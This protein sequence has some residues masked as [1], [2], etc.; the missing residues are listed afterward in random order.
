MKKKI[1]YLVIKCL[2]LSVLFVGAFSTT[3][4]AANTESYTYGDIT[5]VTVYTG[6]SEP[7][8]YV[9]N[10]SSSASGYQTI[11]SYVMGCDVTSIA[12]SAFDYCS[13]ITGVSIPSSITS[14]GANAFT[15]CTSLTNVYIPSSVTYI[16]EYAFSGCSSLSSVSLPK[17]TTINKYTFNNCKNLTSVTIPAG[18][19]TINSFAFSNCTNLTSI[20]IPDSVKTIG[21]NAFSGCNNLKDIHYSEN[22]FV[23]N[24]ITIKS[25][26]ECLEKATW[27]CLTCETHAYTNE[28]DAECNECGH[29]REAP[30]VYTNECDADCNVCDNQRSAH[31]YEWIIDAEPSCIDGLKHEECTLCHN[32]RSNDTI[33]T[34]TGKHVY[35]DKNDTICNICYRKRFYINYDLNGGKSGPQ[36]TYAETKNIQISGTVPSKTGYVFMGWNVLGDNTV[37][38][39]PNDTIEFKDDIFLIA[40]WK[41]E[42]KTCNNSGSLSEQTDC[43]HCQGDGSIESTKNCSSCGGSGNITESEWKSCIHCDGRGWFVDEITGCPW[44]GKY[45]TCSNSGTPCWLCGSTNGFSGYL[46]GCAGCDENGMHEIH[47]D[48]TRCDGEGGDYST[49]T[50]SCVGCGGTGKRTTTSTCSNCSGKGFNTTIFT[51][52]ACNGGTNCITHDYDFS[53]VINENSHKRVCSTCGHIAIEEHTWDNG[54]LIAPPTDTTSGLR[55]FKC[56]YCTATKEEYEAVN[57]YICGDVTGD[58]I[59]NGFDIIRL[60]KYL[61]NYDDATETSS[62]DISLGADANGD[63]N[64]NGFDV[65]RLKKYL[66][67]PDDPTMFYKITWKN[68]DGTVLETDTAAYG[69]IPTYDGAT[70]TK[71]GTEA[72]LYLFVG[73]DKIVSSATSDVTYTATFV[74]KENKYTVVWKNYDGSILETDTDVLHGA[75]PTFDGE[76]P[77]KKADVMYAYTFKGWDM[78]ASA[79]TKDITYTAIYTRIQLCDYVVN[80]D[81]NGGVNAPNAQGKQKNQ[82]L[83][84]SSTVPTR[85]GYIF[86][87]WN[88]LYESTVYQAGSAFNSNMNLTMFAMWEMQCDQCDGTG[89]EMAQITCSK[90][91]GAGEITIRDICLDC[92]GDG[93]MA[94]DYRDCTYCFGPGD[95]DCRCSGRGYIWDINMPDSYC[96][97]CNGT[98]YIDRTYACSS[99]GGK[100]STDEYVACSKCDGTKI[101]KQVAP[102]VDSKDH[103]TISLVEKNGYEYSI[104]GENWQTSG[105]FEDL[106][107]ETEYIFYQRIAANDTIPFGVTSAPLTE[108]TRSLPK[109][110]INY[111]LDGGTTSNPKT[112]T[113]ESDT[114]VLSAPKK[115]GYTFTGWTG[116]GYGD[117]TMDISIPTGSTGNLSFEAHWTINQYTISFNTSGGSSVDSITQ[118]YGTNVTAPTEPT[119]AEK[120]FAGWYD[121]TLTTEYTFDT[122]PAQNITLYAKWVNYEVNLDCDN[123]T[124]ISVNDTITNPE[125]YNAKATDTD[126]NPVDI[127]AT[128]VGGSQT[129]GDTITIRLVAIGLYGVY[130]VKTISNIKVY[131][132][133]VIVF[134]TSKDSIN[135]SDAIDADL[136][137]AV[138]T[139]SHGENVSVSLSVKESSFD[140]GD[141][142]TIIISATDI[143]GNTRIIEIPNVRVYG[144]P[145]ISRDTTITEMKETDIV[146]SE[147][148][149]VTAIDSFGTPLAVTTSI[150]SGK[151]SA[152][153]IISVKSSVTDGNGNYQEITYDVKVYGLPTISN[154]STTTFKTSDNITLSSLGVVAKDSF[155]NTLENVSLELIEGMQISGATLKYTVTA[156]DHLG[157]VSTKVI[158]D[159]KIYDALTITYDTNKLSMNV[160]DK[161]DASLFSAVAKDS[162]NN[163]VNVVVTLESGTFAGGNIVQYRLTA[164]DH[165]GNTHYV[166][167]EGIKVYSSDNITLNYS[168]AA[169]NYIKKDSNGEEFYASATNG[170]GETCSTKIV[171]ATGYSIV[172]GKTINLYI[173]ATDCMGNTK[174]SELISNI[175]IYDTPTIS[176]AREYDYIQNGDSP[177]ALFSVKD[178]FGG[179]LLFDIEIVSGSLDVNETIRYRITSKDRAGNKI[180]KEYE[181]VVLAENESILELYKDNMLVGTQRVVKGESYSL[182]CYADDVYIWCIGFTPFTDENGN[183]LAVWDKDSNGYKLTANLRF[184]MNGSAIEGLTDFGKTLADIKIPNNVTSI[185]NDAFKNCTKLTSVIIPNSVTSIGA[186]AFHSCTN[187]TTVTFEE[188]STCTSIGTY[189]FNNCKNLTA[190]E[191]PNSVTIIDDYAFSNCKKLSS[192]VVPNSVE[193][194]GVYAFANCEKLATVSFEDGSKC[195]KLDEGAFE[196]CTGLSSITLPDALKTIGENAFNNCTSLTGIVVP[197]S[198]TSIGYAAFSGCT[199][200]EC[201]T[202]P[203]ICSNSPWY[204][205]PSRHFGYMFGG[206][207]SFNYISGY[208]YAD[209]TYTVYNSILWY[210]FNIP[211]SLKEVVITKA[212]SIDDEAFQNCTNLTSITIPKSVTSIGASAFSGCTNLKTFI[213]EDGS[214]CLSIAG[215]AFEDCK[216]LTSIIIPKSVERINKNAFNGCSRITIYC[217]VSKKPSGW[218]SEWNLDYVFVNNA[219]DYHNIY[220]DVVWGYKG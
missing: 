176:Y 163:T 55:I 67:S 84:L 154:A 31:K 150:C 91:S 109:Y 59:I 140:S 114:I 122:M 17:I 202:I 39:Q 137:S 49:T 20:T 7:Y 85:E 144:K 61:A 162:F 170:F 58:G 126:G 83:V 69:T 185:G 113:I 191:I 81:A 54:T 180:E 62:V 153:N 124:K 146:S 101:E 15:G 104:D 97:P 216:N 37:L 116:N 74:I 28:C 95:T 178:S 79:V 136:F 10:C 90:C 88:N 24:Q 139:D 8:A 211:V 135:I 188:N 128:I 76:T 56:N 119:W 157:N 80:Y 127:T 125:L 110:N 41:K 12:S 5:Y 63:G 94:G 203:S 78:A 89:S 208:H 34:A 210:K 106:R 100:G 26:N 147:F 35:S 48:C 168:S 184:I 118:D 72:Y 183:S 44:Y 108:T 209:D 73:W 194:I 43:S 129:G 151:H 220:C 196:K 141:Q 160:T 57:N 192:I 96:R 132:E 148:F 174:Q 172:G 102:R 86:A 47:T 71:K 205:D 38:Y 6:Y 204:V 4:Y 190:I 2:I 182:P 117:P 99:C 200:L 206:T 149:G 164:T 45:H 1:T 120:S 13:G 64:V 98:G 166:I 133:P 121:S 138:G 82:V 131:D 87:G 215:D 75:M 197:D 60:K 25:G 130:D 40:V 161:A 19:T 42:C 152:G 187:L 36:N 77:T 51:C 66:A 53:N 158:S 169:S 111:D 21:E 11:K 171:A 181:L 105:L 23:K 214:K 207:S 107:P 199:S 195:K 179:E 156:T 30:H 167:T 46:T 93:K 18:V 115:E 112:Y 198:V 165:L 50:R 29:L 52:S 92:Y 217:E 103:Y 14:I 213:F 134:N 219:I 32:K 3:A 9:S 65:I 189:A 142:V 212:T 177:Y 16:G 68:H 201:M 173:V 27:N 22:Y 33:I 145:A 193:S 123:I 159:I 143:V 175:K 155:G 70:P 186:N 218:D